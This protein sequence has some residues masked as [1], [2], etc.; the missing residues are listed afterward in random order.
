MKAVIRTLAIGIA[1]ALALG[2]AA[3]ARRPVAKA[4]SG[5]QNWNATVSRTDHDSYVLGNPNAKLKLVAFIS[6]TCPH[7]AAF[8]REAEAPLRMTLIGSGKG[9]L[10]VRSYLRDP[11]DLT[12]AMLTHCGPADRFFLNNAAFLGSQDSWIKPMVAPSPQQRQ[13]WGAGTLTQ[14]ARYIAADFHFYEI[15]D[16]RGYSR[17]EVD[18]CLADSALA[19]RLADQTDAAQKR[20][21]IQG[22]PSFLIDDT[23]L[24]GTY[25]WDALRP[26]IEA[27]L[28]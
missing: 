6:Y 3:P 4:D 23:L 22:T 8:E 27:R 14:R 5:Q 1:A 28:D 10:E 17:A 9:S 11:V 2:G 21:G 18:R 15:M 19:K 24:A 12:V 25:S 7:C 13:R 20:Y 26:Q 16:T